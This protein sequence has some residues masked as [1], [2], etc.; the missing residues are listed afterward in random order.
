MASPVYLH[1][2]ARRVWVVD[3]QR[4]RVGLYS[5]DAPPRCVEGDGVLTDDLL[6]GFALPLSVLF[7][8]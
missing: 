4:K 5:P 3:P 8:E 1:N 7:E 2:G 6:P